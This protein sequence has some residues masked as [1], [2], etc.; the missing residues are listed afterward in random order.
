[1]LIRTNYYVYS[2]QVNK[3]CLNNKYEEIT[4]G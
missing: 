3:L 4:E 2:L 1:M